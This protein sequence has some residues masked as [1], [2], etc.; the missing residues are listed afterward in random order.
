MSILSILVLAFVNNIG[1]RASR[2]LLTLFALNLGAQ[3]LT[4]GLLAAT[5]GFF[6]ML[7][8]WWSGRL[9]DRFGARWLLTLG[10]TSS[11]IGMTLPFFNP[12]LPAI[13]AAAA[14]AGLSITVYQVSLQNLVGLLSAPGE[15]A[16]NFSN[17]SLA[18]ATSG[19]V[20]PILAG[21]SIDHFGYGSACVYLAALPLVPIVMLLL[22]GG[23]LPKGSRE[24]ALRARWPSP[25][26]GASSP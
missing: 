24:A 14:L 3:P 8:S 10:A 23:G 15:R 26:C 16:R 20:G 19:F 13:F 25:A 18:G 11:V 12:G 17:Y 4:I 1:S 7:F 5:I 22:H 6:P 2:V 21:L 9:S